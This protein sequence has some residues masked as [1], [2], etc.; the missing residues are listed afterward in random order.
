[1]SDAGTQS[2]LNEKSQDPL[3]KSIDP[4]EEEQTKLLSTLDSIRKTLLKTKQR[5]RNRKTQ[6]SLTCSNNELQT[7]NS[8][9]RSTESSPS[10]ERVL[11]S[12]NEN[13]YK[14][15]YSQAQSNVE[16]PR[17]G[18]LMPSLP[19]PTVNLMKSRMLSHN[20]LQQQ[21]SSFNTTTLNFTQNPLANT[22]TS[23]TKMQHLSQLG[24]SQ[25]PSKK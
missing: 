8:A 25:G 23:P 3:F 14:V 12:P 5:P 15:F 24:V 17:T 2:Y 6:I 13:K 7:R 22:E 4:A 11:G 19:N 9:R 1:M 21:N 16:T 10:K 20:L 18:S